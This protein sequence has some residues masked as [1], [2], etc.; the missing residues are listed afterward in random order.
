MRYLVLSDVHANVSALEAVL[1]NAEFR[2][3]DDVMFLGDAVGYY[4]QAEEAVSLLRSLEPS[5][6]IL[7][8]HDAVLLAMADGAP[9]NHREDGIVTEVLSRHLARLGP[10]SMA[11]L[12]SLT[13]AAEGEA[14]QAVHGALRAPWEYL[15]TLQSAQANLPLLTRR[16][17][18]V[19]HTHVPRIYASVETPDGGLWRTIHFRQERTLYRVPPRA[20]LFVNPGSVGQPRDS[21]PLAAYAL[22]DDASATLE[23]FRVEF[24]VAAMQ[25]EVRAAG[26]PEVLAARLAVGR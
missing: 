6:R 5:V 16:V 21:I 8:N 2:G 1:R 13:Q 3:Y 10:E 15:A 18:F 24:D 4:P 20:R 17:C 11:F 19:G 12:R 22:Y 7:G 23:M 9:A 14:W 25:A 26:Y